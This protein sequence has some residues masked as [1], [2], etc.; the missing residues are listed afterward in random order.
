MMHGTTVHGAQMRAPARRR[1]PP[2]YYHPAGPLGGQVAAQPAGARIG[3]VGLGTGA[4]AAL[5]KAGQT[6]HVYEIDA[7]VE[8]LA[9]RHFSFL[10][11]APAEVT[12]AIVDG[13]LGLAAEPDG[14]LDLLVEDAF[15]GDAVPAH[16]LTAEALELARRKLRPN[17]LAVFHVSNRSLDLARVFRGWS[18]R[19][20]HPVA[21]QRWEPGPAARREG[22]TTTLAVAV[23]A[24]DAVVRRLVAE[25]AGA[26]RLL[27]VAGAAVRWTD[28]RTSL[29][30]VL[31]TPAGTR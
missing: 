5:T 7:L 2:A 13:R 19:T 3:L 8:E 23:A 29:V 18:A 1:V 16:L 10:A 11:D 25:S 9:R 22:A 30:G 24:D 14:S 27:D 4:L 12:V 17:G 6:V 15:T 28:D 21:I 31:G 20:G 26:W